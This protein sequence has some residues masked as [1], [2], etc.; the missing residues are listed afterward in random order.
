MVDTGFVVGSCVHSGADTE[1][2]DARL[3]HDRLAPI[4]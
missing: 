1:Q 4:S 2:R 3:L